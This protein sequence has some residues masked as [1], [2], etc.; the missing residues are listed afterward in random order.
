M[1][2][3]ETKAACAVYAR[4]HRLVA[5]AELLGWNIKLH[6]LLCG[7]C[8]GMTRIGL[9]VMSWTRWVNITG[10][11]FRRHGEGYS[12]SQSQR[13]MRG[14]SDVTGTQALKSPVK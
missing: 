11:W 14:S 1:G 4:R 12:V 2:E 9:R 3:E 5:D 10:S 13:R 8:R 7:R 6:A